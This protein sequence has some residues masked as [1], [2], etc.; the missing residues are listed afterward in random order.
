MWSVL[1]FKWGLLHIV[2]AVTS[3]PINSDFSRPYTCVAL[4]HLWESVLAC[5]HTRLCTM[6]ILRGNKVIAKNMS[7]ISLILRRRTDVGAARLHLSGLRA[8]IYNFLK[9][10]L[11]FESLSPSSVPVFSLSW[12]LSLSSTN[13][14]VAQV[15]DQRGTICPLYAWVS[16]WFSIH[17][18][19]QT[20]EGGQG[21]D[22]GLPVCQ[23]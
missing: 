22:G 10:H 19:D 18:T 9:S 15:S 4:V 13:H 8:L 23:S 12:Q 1:H 7:E 14:T 3:S 11:C 6:Q 5:A 17:Y 2:R 21:R 20:D 16:K